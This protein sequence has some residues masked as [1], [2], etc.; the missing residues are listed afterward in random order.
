MPILNRELQRLDQHASQITELQAQVAQLVQH[1]SEIRDTRQVISQNNLVFTWTGGTLTLSWPAGYIQDSSLRNWAIPA[2]S[3]VLL[4]SSTYWLGWNPLQQHMASS[5]NLNTLLTGIS[6]G[7]PR[8]SAG[9][10]LI[11]C[12]VKTGTA[13]QTGT[14]GGGGSDPGGAGPSGK[15]YILF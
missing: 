11:V 13:G 5:T 14:A 12:S 7:S 9:N 10:N 3:L 8:S 2:G 1:T 6:F 4:A 15:Q